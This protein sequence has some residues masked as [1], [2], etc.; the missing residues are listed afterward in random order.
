[1]KELIIKNDKELIDLAYSLGHPISSRV[2]SS[3]IDRLVPLDN[4]DAH[5]QSLSANYGTSEFPFHTDGAYFK[6]PPKFIILRYL[7]GIQNPTPTVLCDLN[8]LN[9]EANQKLKDCIWKVKSRNN[10]FLTTI[11]SESY[12]CYRYDKCIMTPANIKLRNK[13]YFENLIDELPKKHI[14]WYT[15]KTV[16]IDNWTFLHSRP[17]VTEQEINNRTIQRIMVI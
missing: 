3:F 9:D 1:M 6:I 2:N 13:N 11:L 8:Q 12:K 10:E 7:K 16:I 14:N 17:K 15:N 4:S 5:K